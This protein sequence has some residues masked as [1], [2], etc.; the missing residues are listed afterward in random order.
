MSH[1]INFKIEYFCKSYFVTAINLLIGI[2]VVFFPIIG[3]EQLRESIFEAILSGKV[4]EE[5]FHQHHLV[6]GQVRPAVSVQ[7]SLEVQFI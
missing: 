5:V 6:F 3:E 2:T 7:V 1:I 4:Q